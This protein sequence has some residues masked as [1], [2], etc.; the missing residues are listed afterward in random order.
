MLY[1]YSIIK[2]S[3]Y[4]LRTE[5]AGYALATY[6]SKVV[7]IGGLLPMQPPSRDTYNKAVVVLDDQFRLGENL[8][9]ALKQDPNIHNQFKFKNACAVGT[10]RFLIIVGAV[11]SSD[12]WLLVYDGQGW[13]SGTVILKADVE[14]NSSSSWTLHILSGELYMACYDSCY[15]DVFHTSLESLVN[16]SD[17]SESHWNVIEN[18][19]GR[20]RPCT[21]TLGN[22][23]I[24]MDTCGDMLNIY[25]Y[26]P[27]SS[28]WVKVEDVPI[29]LQC[30]TCVVS[31]HS[32]CPTEQVESII[33][34]RCSD[35]SPA[36]VFRMTTKC[37]LP[38][39]YN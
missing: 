32:P 30:L 20:N 6:Q 17:G 29:A 39:S 22:H 36:S 23:L 26:L 34:G 19:P 8:N 35:H 7:M 16:A 31:L 12:K 5:A 10:G 18:A 33:V 14:L 3:W 11:Y 2:R 9:S 27:I 13:K 25:A 28:K 15:R 1:K 38:I 4:K 21:M 24:M 37:M